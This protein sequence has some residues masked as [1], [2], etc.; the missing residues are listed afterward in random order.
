MVLGSTCN[1]AAPLC[2]DYK[3]LYQKFKQISLCKTIKFYDDVELLKIMIYYWVGGWVRGWVGREGGRERR[4]E[5]HRFVVTSKPKMISIESIFK[6]KFSLVKVF[7][8]I[9]I[10]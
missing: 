6:R 2:L 7:K 3:L 4:R 5:V 10:F 1:T 9:L 8:Y